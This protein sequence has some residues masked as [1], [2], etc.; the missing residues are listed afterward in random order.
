VFTST[1]RTRNDRPTRTAGKSPALISRYTVIDDTR[2]RSATSWTVKKRASAKDC[3]TSLTP[4]PALGGSVGPR[5]LCCQVWRL[6]PA[7]AAGGYWA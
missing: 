6:A 2:I 1:S 3:A 7:L 4:L 5:G